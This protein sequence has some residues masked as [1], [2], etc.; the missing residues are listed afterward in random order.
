MSELISAFLISD[1]MADRGKKII[2]Q[3]NEGKTEEWTNHQ[4]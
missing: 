2:E 3:I 1:L 4:L